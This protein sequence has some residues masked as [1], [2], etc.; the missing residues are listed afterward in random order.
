MG[1][2]EQ[3]I[4]WCESKVNL[5]IF[6]MSWWLEAASYPLKWDAVVIKKNRKIIA[7]FPFVK[8]E[9]IGFKIIQTPFVTPFVNL[10]IDFPHN[11]S[12]Q[13]MLKFQKEIIN[14]IV[15]K[16]PDF[17]HIEVRLHPQLK[18]PLPLIWNGFKTDIRFTNQLKFQNDINLYYNNL[19]PSLKRNIKKAEKIIKFYES[20]DLESFLNL[21][22]MTF[23]R[24][25]KKV[26]YHLN[27]IEKIDKIASKKNRRKILL[28]KDKKNNL[29]AGVYLVWD[30]KY[31]YYLMGGSNPKYRESQAL[32][33]LMWNAI[34]FSHQEKKSFDFEGS[35]IEP[36]EIF[37]RSFNADPIPYFQIKKTNSF[38]LKIKDFFMNI[39]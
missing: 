9:K 32:S 21:Y 23:L 3:Y 39:Q 33:L 28:A 31:I 1:D 26:P 38:I 16:L 30:E 37:F 20:S 29:H 25:G 7:T 12:K 13:N 15:K 34:K 19:K 6:M 18:Y 22:K 35:M 10:W 24:Q 8:K 14:E 17:D 4:K 2:K 11:L 5:P 36:I 27:T